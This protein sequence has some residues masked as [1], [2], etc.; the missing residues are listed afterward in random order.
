[1]IRKSH[2]Q[3]LISL[4]VI[5]VCLVVTMGQKKA[6]ASSSEFVD[7][8]DA[9]KNQKPEVD[10]LEI[11]LQSGTII[12]P[13]NDYAEQDASWVIEVDAKSAESEVSAEVVGTETAE[14]TP[15]EL[16]RQE[17]LEA[18]RERLVE[19]ARDRR[20]DEEAERDAEIMA[21]APYTEDDVY[22]VAQVLQVEAGNLPSDQEKSA[23]VWTIL[24]RVDLEDKFGESIAEVA[25]AQGQFDYRPSVEPSFENINLVRDVMNR[26]Y[27]EQRGFENSG[28]TLP[29]EYLYFTG[30]GKTNFFRKNSGSG[31][32]YNW[33]LENPYDN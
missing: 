21:N 28:R 10:A 19:A 11:P 6:L 17:E 2:V 33:S 14:L 22:V 29:E 20:L 25:K 31:G 13:V 27:A 23:V 8:F 3:M 15:E 24:N 18:W 7:R 4:L 5:T 32:Y 12:I 16:A 1:M 30:N 26:W 9:M